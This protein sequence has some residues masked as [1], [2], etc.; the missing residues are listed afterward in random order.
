MTFC[1]ISEFRANYFSFPCSVWCGHDLPVFLFWGDFILKIRYEG[2]ICL[3]VG[4]QLFTAVLNDHLCSVEYTVIVSV[5]FPASAN[6]RCKIDKV[7]R[8]Q[9]WCD[10][11]SLA[12]PTPSSAHSDASRRVP[13][14]LQWFGGTDWGERVTLLP[15]TLWP[16]K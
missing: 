4:T 5:A 3:V 12:D 1:L 13:P 10:P 14:R 16:E 6:W 15:I 2:V 8:L 11:C 9:C 7:R